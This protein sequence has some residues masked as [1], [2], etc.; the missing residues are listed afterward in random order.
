MI[1][2]AKIPVIILAVL[3]IQIPY[4]LYIGYQLCD[5]LALEVVI[6]NGSLI[7]YGP[8]QCH[9]YDKVSNAQLYHQLL[10]K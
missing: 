4:T 10:Y 9:N 5:R 3:K 7:G 1:S 2:I 6:L 8:E